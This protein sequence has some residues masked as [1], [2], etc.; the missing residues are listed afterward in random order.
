M[1]KLILAICV[2]DSLPSGPIGLRGWMP[3]WID[4]SGQ[5]FDER[6]ASLVEYSLLLAMIAVVCIGAIT[7][8]GGEVSDVYSGAG[9][10]F[11]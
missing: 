1:L 8:F 10:S 6:G 9:S 3:R 11:N 2:A 4:R 7:F 5:R